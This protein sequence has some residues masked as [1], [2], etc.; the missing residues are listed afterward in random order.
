MGRGN[1]VKCRLQLPSFHPLSLPTTLLP[2]HTSKAHKATQTHSCH[3][4]PGQGWGWHLPS[5]EENRTPRATSETRLHS[6]VQA[7]A[8]HW[9]KMPQKESI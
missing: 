8:L 1:T 3:L 4:C 6:T 5:L 9:K 2:R 7:H